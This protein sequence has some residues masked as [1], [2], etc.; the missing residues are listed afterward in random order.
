MVHLAY[1]TSFPHAAFNPFHSLALLDG[2]PGACSSHGS[3]SSTLQGCTLAVALYTGAGVR[4]LHVAASRRGAQPLPA[5]PLAR[6]QSSENDESNSSASRFLSPESAAAAPSAGVFAASP[7]GQRTPVQPPALSLDSP[8]QQQQQQRRGSISPVPSSFLRGSPSQQQQRRHWPQP[9]P[10]P[11]GRLLASPGSAAGGEELEVQ[12]ALVACAH[13][14]GGARSS[15]S[16]FWQ[17]HQRLS[18]D[19]AGSS[20][21]MA[22]VSLTVLPLQLDL[23]SCI[24][25]ALRLQ[26]LPPAALADYAAAPVQAGEWQGQDG[27]LLL[28]VL[29]LVREAA[30]VADQ[31]CVMPA[32][33]ATSCTQAE[34]RGQHAPHRSACALLH[35]AAPDGTARL[36][37]WLEPPY[38]WHDDLSTFLVQQ[39][40]FAGAVRGGQ[41]AGHPPGCLWA[42][43]H[44]Q[45]SWSRASCCHL[46]R[47]PSPHAGLAFEKAPA[48]FADFLARCYGSGLLPRDRLPVVLTNRSVL[49]SGS[50]LS[51]IVHPWLPQAVLGWGAARM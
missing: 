2:S 8:Q 33:A 34:K 50:S 23:E 28:A 39:T 35:A 14:Y 32:A 36:V 43:T 51:H 5:S 30:P 4:Y 29:R 48:F 45:G 1:H 17:Q 22:A 24:F 7:A 6:Q 12:T 11:Q 20:G 13:A 9:H 18:S 3:I 42:S 47:P 44:A 37:E 10:A 27:L 40:A 38:P 26:G 15:S 49:G 25:D 21:A 31:G 41:A 16:H 46:L 19:I